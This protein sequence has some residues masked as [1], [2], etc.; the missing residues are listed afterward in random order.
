[1]K[2]SIFYFPSLIFHLLLLSVFA[3]PAAAQGSLENFEAE[4]A[5][6][7]HEA[8]S[9]AGTAAD[10]PS[11]VRSAK[12]DE[13]EDDGY[14]EL[15]LSLL[16]IGLIL[17]QALAEYAGTD[18][19]FGDQRADLRL[20]HGW[21]KGPLSHWA[22]D[23]RVHLG[24][25]LGLSAGYLGYRER[26]G[27]RTDHLEFYRANARYQVGSLRNSAGLE[28]GGRWMTGGARSYSGL[29]GALAIDV[30]PHE[31]VHFDASYR[32]SRLSASTICESAI[33]VTGYYKS[34]G[35][36]F[37]YRNLDSGRS[38]LEGIEAGVAVGF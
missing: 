21:D 22:A 38:H 31:A 6:P 17:P 10:T 7:G 3:P 27:G 19:L 35:L 32:I 20:S 16:R 11:T 34:V 9:R 4:V 23:G 30:S 24:R 13:D 37:G 25:G 14:L 29:D 18:E 2:F 15:F 28:L 8:S 1:M 12:A 36:R 33:G 5:R 26:I